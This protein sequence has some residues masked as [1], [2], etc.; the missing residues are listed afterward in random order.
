M[1]KRLFALF[2]CL[3][4]VM[5]LL[6]VSAFAEGTEA[7]YGLVGGGASVTS[8]NPVET[9]DTHITFKF[10]N[11][12]TLLDTQVV[13]AAGQLTAPATPAIK[14]GRKFLGWYAVDANDQ[15]EAQEFNF[16]TAYTTYSGRSEVKVMAKFEAVFYVYFMTVE[17]QVHSTAIANEANGF[18]V[19]PPKDYEPKGKVV[20]GWKANDAVFTADTVVS[21][22]TYVYPDTEDCYWVTFNTT[23]GSMVASRS[24]TKGAT[25]EL[26]GVTAP[27]RTGYRFKGWSTTE[28]GALISS[29]TP[30][31]DTT[32][33]AVWE[34]DNVTY[35]VVYWGEN[36]NNTAT[37]N[38]PFDTLL[39]T[40]SKTAKVGTTVTGSAST[41]NNN[42]IKNYFTYHSSDSAVVKADNSTVI[43]VYYTRKSF[44]VTFDLGTTGSKSMTIGDNTYRSGWN[45]TKYVLTA[46][47]GQNIESLW[48]TASNFSSGSNFYAW[49]ISG[50]SNLAVS[51]RLTMTADLCSSNGKTATA[52]YGTNCLDHLFYMFESFDQTSPANGNE[53]QRFN[54]VYYDKSSEYSQDANSKGGDWGQ[55]AI[56][57]MKAS[58]TQTTVLK[59]DGSWFDPDPKRA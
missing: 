57:G 11:G 42:T 3:C 32:L 21:A 20:T 36:P 9:P 19:T 37:E 24:V 23:G 52:K 58:G 51:K 45:A 28:G 7:Q 13:N 1:K 25:L 12:E 46:K 43:N 27:T 49:N 4:M 15:L 22:D 44:S 59:D 34:G 14:G 17:G 31:A 35:T 33:Y 8:V 40:E 18:K 50:V 16:S 39:G 26:S 30:T 56:T 55:K 6:P 29:V 54:G 48:P 38:I 2:L 41:A 5:T 53:R 47:Y 10:Y